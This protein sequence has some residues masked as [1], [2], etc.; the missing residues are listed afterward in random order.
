MS[1]ITTPR[2]GK[3]QDR[4]FGQLRLGRISGIHIHADWS[5]LIIVGLV[6]ANLGLGLL[7][8]WHPGWSF[9]TTWAVSIGAAL[10]F[11]ASILVHELSHALVGRRM[12]IVVRHITL[13]V[14][15]G[16]AHTENEPPSP[17]A[18]AL[19]A[20]V[21]PLTSLAL[22]VAS[23]A[24]GLALSESLLTTGQ[25]P[26]AVLSG[27][28]PVATLLLWLGPINVILGVFNLVPGFPLDGGRVLRAALWGLTGDL[29][30]ATRWA[31]WSGQGFAALLAAWGIVSLV[32]GMIV[33]G[34]WLLFIGWFLRNA[35][36]AGYR[37]TMLNAAL[38][39]TRVGELMRRHLQLVSPEM[40][41]SRLIQGL[42]MRCDQG[43]YPVVTDGQ[44]LQG[45]VFLEDVRKVPREAWAHTSV[46]S[47]MTPI[48]ELQ[49]TGEHVEATE[50]LRHFRR[51]DELP[52]VDA[53]GILRGL[54]RRQD[55]LRW[56]SLRDARQPA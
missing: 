19:M 36:R 50:I 56:L 54:I 37:Q 21:G 17:K 44:Q 52:V 25:S 4:E 3:P 40:P 9:V 20:G 47:A 53:A 30:K 34:V 55:V 39:T 5:V 24:G 51:V 31:S 33:Q 2:A 13:F 6:A 18:E 49:T 28:G 1:S 42:S 41:L 26:A 8:T 38:G 32:E 43:C 46:A 10:L 23:I 48:T 11:L 29:Q 14:F 27:M 15:G 12:G 45:V 7:P 35:A 16:M 22:G